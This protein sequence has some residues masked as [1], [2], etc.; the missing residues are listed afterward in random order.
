MQNDLPCTLACVHLSPEVLSCLCL[1][2]YIPSTSFVPLQQHP[3]IKPPRVNI[4]YY[5]I[6]SASEYPQ[7]R[8]ES[9]RSSCALAAAAVGTVQETTMRR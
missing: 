2:V 3:L 1:S 4:F 5:W 9:P 6:L 8:L 7:M